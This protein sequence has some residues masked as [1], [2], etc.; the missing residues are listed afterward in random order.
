M[1]VKGQKKGELVD[2]FTVNGAYQLF[3]ENEIGK[4]EVGYKADILGYTGNEL[5]FVITDGE[6]V[7]VK[8]IGEGND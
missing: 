7:Y 1:K 2:G 8:S 6:I 4:I 5:K 3:R